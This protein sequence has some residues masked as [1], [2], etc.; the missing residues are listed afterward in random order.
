MNE[1]ELINQQMQ[2]SAYW[3]TDLF[4]YIW[5]ASIIIQLTIHLLT[6]WGLWKINKKLWEPH[7]WV[8]WIPLV[9]I[10]SY[11]R[12][13][14]YPNIWILWLVLWIISIIIPIVGIIIFLI[15]FIKVLHSISKRC[16]KWVWTTIGLFFIPFIM[17]PIL[18]YN[19]NPKNKE[20]TQSKEDIEL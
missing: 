11:V 16:W 14:W 2:L 5:F 19:C 6:A 8:S 1:M 17:F 20:N 18:A 3:N 10:Y 7:A 9:N 15:L 12:A 4:A 13:A